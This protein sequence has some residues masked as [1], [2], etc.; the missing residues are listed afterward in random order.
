M[1]KYEIIKFVDCDFE[2]DVNVSS[3]QNT[4][5][6]TQEQIAKL[7]EKSRSTITEHINNIFSEGELYEMTSVGNSDITNHRPA[8]LYN[9][10]VILA[11]GYRVKSK[12]GILF[13]RWA[14][15]V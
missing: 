6:S 1:E 8:K 2:L 7:F 14:L 5:L 4:I 12:R 11:V 10:D 9:L 13:R 15:V 3:R